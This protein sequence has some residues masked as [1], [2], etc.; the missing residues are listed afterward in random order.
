MCDD[1]DRGYIAYDYNN[2]ARIRIKSSIGN[3]SYIYITG[4][5]TSSQHTAQTTPV[6]HLTIVYI[7]GRKDV[8]STTHVTLH[9]NLNL[10]EM[11][12]R[13]HH[14]GVDNNE[15]DNV[16]YTISRLTMIQSVHR[17]IMLTLLSQVQHPLPRR[18]R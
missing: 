6:K 1:K 8:N 11:H 18:K 13:R 5:S 14:T 7:I 9:Q 2:P 15:L 17:T 12:I 3:V 4:A 16:M 10:N